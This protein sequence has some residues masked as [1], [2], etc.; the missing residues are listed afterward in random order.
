MAL[1]GVKKRKICVVTTSRA[2]YGLLC[3]LMKEIEDDPDLSLSVIATGMHLAAAFGMTADVIEKDGFRIDKRI[4]MLLSSDSES[5]IVK[6]MG[7][8]MIS[9]ADALKEIGPDIVVLLGD[10]FE[11]VPIALAAVVFRIP[12]AHIH[13]GETS[14]GAID[15]VFRHSLTKMASI[16]FPATETYRTRILQMGENP[17]VTFNFGAPGLDALYRLPLLNRNE[18]E[19]A[20]RF[21]LEGI[22]AIVTYHPVTTEQGT[23]REQIDNLLAAIEASGIKAVFTKANADTGGSV[24][25]ARV[26]EFCRA[27]P[28]RFKLFDSLGQLKY[29]SC[30]KNLDLML[31]NSSSGLIEAPSFGLPV[32]NI[33]ER[34]RGRMR[35]ANVID[36]D[37]STESI[38]EGIGRALS[39]DFRA[40]LE[41]MGNPYDRFRDGKTS[42]RIKEKLK[43]I[44]L[45]ED[46]I[47]KEFRDLA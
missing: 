9:F 27:N 25:N 44:E 15:E 39:H 24:I 37:T 6:S 31:G 21:K 2:D 47:R 20:L 43:T 5:G 12:L 8:A 38:G 3:W 16:H 17:D 41:T 45:S 13:G 14:Q 18:L 36:A 29:L 30:L 26:E 34:Q 23:A 10:R 32:V 19:T 35:A 28:H 1:L 46:L 4:E 33:G 42:L 40:G 11:I 22:V 7:V